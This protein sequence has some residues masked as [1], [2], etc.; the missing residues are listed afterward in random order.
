MPDLC[1]AAS[2]MLDARR[3]RRPRWPSTLRVTWS[4]FGASWL[5]SLMLMPVLLVALSADHVNHA[6]DRE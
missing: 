2:M 4:G 5:C 1:L 6:E 3:R